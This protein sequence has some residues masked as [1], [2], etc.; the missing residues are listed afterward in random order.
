MP[1]L[2]GIC[3]AAMDAVSKRCLASGIV[4]LVERRTLGVHHRTA[5]GKMLIGL[6]CLLALAELVL[7][8][9]CVVSLGAQSV[10]CCYGSLPKLVIV[11][12]GGVAPTDFGNGEDARVY[13]VL[14]HLLGGDVLYP[15]VTLYA[16]DEL[17]RFLIE[18]LARVI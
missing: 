7:E 13:H 2:I 3:P 6:L 8:V 12:S 18:P 15:Q 17:C 9:E 10:N 16:I 5:L 11:A 1:L 14:Y 4:L